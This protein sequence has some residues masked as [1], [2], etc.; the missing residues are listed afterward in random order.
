L[1]EYPYRTNEP[2]SDGERNQESDDETVGNEYTVVM[3]QKSEAV[4]ERGYC[5]QERA[6]LLLFLTTYNGH[7]KQIKRI[8]QN[9]MY[10]VVL[11]S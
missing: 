11:C 4:R 8:S 7:V 9:T 1:E 6:R 5:R 10:T 2:S 3:N